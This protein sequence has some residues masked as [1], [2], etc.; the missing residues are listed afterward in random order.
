MNKKRGRRLLAWLLAVIITATSAPVTAFAAEEITSAETSVEESAVTDKEPVQNDSPNP[1]QETEENQQEQGAQPQEVPEDQPQAAVNGQPQLPEGTVDQGEIPQDKAAEPEVQQ[2]E[3][4]QPADFTEN[5]EELHISL[6]KVNYRNESGADIEIKAEDKRMDLT[7]LTKAELQKLTLGYFAQFAHEG[8][9]KQVQEGDSFHIVIPSEFFKAENTRLPVPV[10]N[11]DAAD[12]TRNSEVQVAQYEIKDNVVTV[13]FI[14]GVEAED[15]SYVKVN[16]QVKVAVKEAALR[17]DGNAEVKLEREDIVMALPQV[18]EERDKIDTDNSD[19]KAEEAGGTS[20]SPELPSEEAADEE[21]DISYNKQEELKEENKQEKETVKNTQDAKEN[22]DAQSKEEENLFQRFAKKAVSFFANLG[23]NE[24]AAGEKETLSKTF[25]N[26]AAGVSKATIQ[27][28]YQKDGYSKGDDL[29]VN[30]GLDLRLDDAFLFQGLEALDGTAGFPQFDDS[31]ETYKEY[32]ARLDKYLENLSEDNLPSITYIYDLGTDFT[33]SSDKDGK[34]QSLKVSTGE[35]DG[36]GNPVLE[37]IGTLTV[38]KQKEDKH[39]VAVV[40]F[41]KKA[42]NRD[43]VKAGMS[44]D[45]Q[46]SEDA[47]KDDEP[48][49]VGWRDDMLVVDIEGKL[50]PVDPNE[51]EKSDYSIEKTSLENVTTPYIDYTI[52]VNAQNDK[53]LAGMVLEDILPKAKNNS[54]VILNVNAV[55]LDNEDLLEDKEGNFQ[56]D[57][58]VVKDGKLLYQ[59]PADST[60]VKAEFTVRLAL[61]AD[62]YKTAISSQ[63]GVAF[64]FSNTA[65][66]KN[67]DQSKTEVTSESADTDMSLKLMQ[68]DGKQDGI[69]GLRYSW[70]LDINT[71]FSHMVDAYIADTICWS[72]HCYEDA[73]GVQIYVDGKYKETLKMSEVSVADAIS[74][75]ALSKENIGQV[76]GGRTEPFYYKYTDNAD[77]KEYAVLII[78]FKD[79]YQNHNVKIKYF[80]NINQHGM[81]VEE[82]MGQNNNESKN[83][84]NDA[85]FIWNRFVYGDG[86]GWDDFEWNVELNKDVSTKVEIGAKK[87]GS[88]DESTQMMSWNFVVNGYGADMVNT[89]IKDALNENLYDYNTIDLRYTKYSRNG[90]DAE[91]GIITANPADN[92]SALSYV[93]DNSS[94]GRSLNITVG[95]VTAHEYYEIELKVKVTDV[96]L[97]RQ[98]GNYE[99]KNQAVISAE[100]NGKELSNTLEASKNVPQTLIAKE[101]VGEYNYE[102]RELGWKTTIDMNHVKIF[103]GVV[104]DTLPEGNSFGTIQKVTRISRDAKGAKITEE[105]I[106]KEDQKTIAFALSDLKIAWNIVKGTKDVVTFTFT[107]STGNETVTDDSYIFEYKTIVSDE[108]YLRKVFETTTDVEIINTAKLTGW[109]NQKSDATAIDASANAEAVHRITSSIIEKNGTYFPGQGAIHWSVTFNKDKVD[110]S[111][112]SLIEEIGSQPLEINTSTL[113]LSEVKADGSKEKLQSSENDERWLENLEPKKIIYKIPNEY[114]KKTM[115]LEFDT[116]L[117]ESAAAGSVNNTARLV[118]DGSDYQKSESSDGGYDGSFDIDDYVTASPKPI[119]Q[120]MKTSSND[121]TTSDKLPLAGAEFTLTAYKK[122]TNGKYAADATY[123]K[124]GVSNDKGKC[125]F[126]NLKKGYV[127]A[128]EET[129]APGGYELR[130]EITYYLF[131]DGTGAASSKT[132][133]TLNVG[134]SDVKVYCLDKGSASNASYIENTTTI[135]N[136]PSSSMEFQFTKNGTADA[137]LQ[138]SVFLLKDKKGYLQEKRKTSGSDGK[139]QFGIIDPGKYTMTELTS[140][141]PYDQGAK[142]DVEMKTDGSYTIKKVSGNASVSGDYTAGYIIKNEYAKGTI[143]FSKADSTNK[144][145]N[146]SGAVFALLDESNNAIKENGKDITATSDSNGIVTFKN[147]PYRE[148]GYIIKEVTPPKGY[149]VSETV[150]VTVEADQI[151]ASLKAA[152][153]TEGKAKSYTLNLGTSESGKVTNIRTKGSITFTKI[154]EAVTTNVLGSREFKLYYNDSDK[155]NNWEQG[156]EVAAAMSGVDGRVTFSDIPYGNYILEETHPAGDN[157]QPYK[158]EF[159]L[160]DKMQNS[161]DANR[162]DSDG[163]N[164][165]LFSVDLGI[166]RNKLLKTSFKIHKTDASTAENLANVTFELKGKNAYNEE[167]NTKSSKTDDKGTAEFKDIPIGEYTLTEVR[168]KGYEVPSP[169]CHK[170]SVKSV[171]QSASGKADNQA[172]VTVKAVDE[173]NNEAEIAPQNNQYKITN[174]PI[175]GEISFKKVSS[176]DDTKYLKGAEFTLYRVVNGQKRTDA[177]GVLAPRTAYS[178]E[179]GK[180]SFKEAE[181]G[182]YILQET[183][184]PDGYQFDQKEIKITKADLLN[185]TTGEVNEFAYTV[186][187][188]EGGIL[189]NKPVELFIEKKDQFGQ[190]VVGAELELIGKLAGESNRETTLLWTTDEQARKDLSEKLIAGNTYTLQ[191][192]STPVSGMYQPIRPVTFTVQEDGTLANIQ[193]ADGEYSYIDG[194][195]TLTDSYYLKHVSLQKRDAFNHAGISDVEF[196]LYRQSGDTPDKE[197]DILIKSGIKT[198]EAGRWD[199]KSEESGIV[200]PVTKGDLS[201]GL[202]KGTYYFAEDSTT[203]NYVLETEP[204]SFTIDE[205]SFSKDAQDKVLEVTVE[206][207]PANASVRLK[208]V[209]G[210]DGNLFVDNTEF[211]LTYPDG[212]TQTFTTEATER[213]IEHINSDGNKEMITLQKGEMFISGLAKGTYSLEE[214]RA[215]VNYELGEEPFKCTFTVSDACGSG[216]VLNINQ[217]GTAAPFNLTLIQGQWN[218]QGVLNERRTGSVS[219]IKKGNPNKDES[220]SVVLPGAEFALFDSQGNPVKDAQGKDIT[221]ITDENGTFTIDGLSWGDYYLQETAAPEGYHLDDTRLEFTISYGQLTK[222]FDSNEPGNKDNVVNNPTELTIEKKADGAEGT[223]TGAVFTIEGKFADGMSGKKEYDMTSTGSRTLLKELI[224][225]ES[226]TLTE[227]TAP[228]GYELAAPI[229]FTVARSGDIV[230]EDEKQEDNTITVEDKPIEVKLIKTDSADKDTFLAGAQFSLRDETAGLDAETVI[231]KGEAVVLPGMIQGHTYTLTETKAPAGYIL[232]QFKPEVRFTVGTDGKV[233]FEDNAEAAITGTKTDTIVVSDN[234]IKTM[235]EKT[236]LTGEKLTGWEFEVTGIFTQGGGIPDDTETVIRVDDIHKDALNGHL[237]AGNRYTIKETKEPEGYILLEEIITIEVQPDGSLKQILEEGAESAAK[238]E[239]NG[240]I[241]VLISDEPTKFFLNKVSSEPNGKEKISGAV[242]EIKDKDGKSLNPM[243]TWTS[244]GTSLGEITHLPKGTYILEETTTPYGYKTAA[245][246]TFTLDEKNGVTLAPGSKGDLAKDGDGNDIITMT[247]TYIRGHVEFTKTLATLQGETLPLADARFSLYREKTGKEE[248][249]TLLAEELTTDSEGK[250]TTIENEIVR[251]DN[252]EKLAKGLG[253]GSYYLVETQAPANAVLNNTKHRFE[254]QAKNHGEDDKAIVKVKAENKE[255]TAEVTLKKIEDAAHDSEGISGAEF[256][257]AYK[258]SGEE[259]YTKLAGEIVTGQNGMATIPNLKKGDYILTE[260]ANQG[261]QQDKF[262]NCRFTISDKDAFKTYQV[263]SANEEISLTETDEEGNPLEKNAALTEKGIENTRI[264]GSVTLLKVDGKKTDKQLKGTEFKLMKEATGEGFINWLTSLFTGRKYQAAGTVSGEELAEDQGGRLTIENL[265]W[266]KYKLIETKAIDGY[267]NDAR[268]LSF[269]I[270]RQNQKA[271]VETDGGKVFNFQNRLTIRKENADKEPLAGA[272]F[273]ITKKGENIPV[274]TVT[275]GNGEDGRQ[276]GEITLTGELVGGATYVLHETKAP[277]G[278]ILPDESADITFTMEEDGRVT[279]GGQQQPDDTIT[280]TNQPIEVKLVKTDS[281]D[282]GVFLEGAEFSLQDE[283]AAQEAVTVTSQGEA[284]LLPGMIQGHTYTLTETKV[285][286]GYIVPNPGLET[287]FRVETDGTVTFTESSAV[288]GTGTDT[289][290]VANEPTR[291]FL[292]KVSNE[293]DGKTR[294]NGAVLEI[295]DADGK[296]LNPQVKWTSDGSNPGEIVNLPKG[297]YMLV[298]TTTPKGYFTAEPIGFE[299]REDNSIVLSQDSSGTAAKGSDGNYTITMT[300]IFI[301]GDVEFVKYKKVMESCADGTLEGVPEAEHSIPVGGAEF[302][303]YQDGQAAKP[304]TKADGSLV[305]A[306]SQAEGKV[307][308]EQIPMGTYYIKETKAPAGCTA[309]EEIYK[310]VINENGKCQGLERTDGSSVEGNVVVNDVLRTDIS[311]KKV[312]EQAPD[313]VLPGSTY[314]LYKRTSEIPKVNAARM[315]MNAPKADS[316]DELEGWTL[317]ATS[318]TDKDGMLTFK[319]VLMDTEYMIRELEA[320]DGS[321]VSEKPVRITF[322]ADSVTGEVK[323]A[324]IDNGDGTAEVN[325]DTGEI[326]WREPPIMLG[327]LKTDEAGVPLPGA[328]L[329][330]Q[331]MEGN[332]LESWISTD[333]Q[334]VIYGDQMG[335]RIKANEQYR[336]AEKKAPKGYAIADPVEFTVEEKLTGPGEEFIQQIVMINIRD[337]ANPEEPEEIEKPVKP[338]KPETPETSET[339]KKPEK[340]TETTKS[341]KSSG[342]NTGDNSPIVPFTLLAVLSLGTA[343]WVRRKRYGKR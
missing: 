131:G 267:K 38:T 142:F 269:E 94:S 157:Y 204:K 7:G 3:K 313:T 149:E 247:D 222:A 26:P 219:L 170:V 43:G 52:T 235:L 41:D 274:R 148:N 200:N 106:I 63:D 62:D 164:D 212:K 209:D 306:V 330:L 120:V 291:F 207:K 175:K 1:G 44:I 325:P 331:D 138:N 309:E 53:T 107:D 221:R 323:I 132:E 297:S 215:N 97:L 75:K 39:C 220:Q 79:T 34:P 70:T 162:A 31:K 119:L 214:T 11:C 194:V 287:K 340:S 298:E 249:D 224:A 263:N 112:M 268:E 272:E 294:I 156:H 35:T 176:E 25:K 124:K 203:E 296:P 260:T 95:N 311:M 341:A 333:G 77:G 246:I 281:Q 338:E 223:I 17:E 51:P 195:L 187:A 93:I 308:F 328:E 288:T 96:N 169:V 261:Y 216:A 213:Q 165:N 151:M 188:A 185:G 163:N 339:P 102:T 196:S 255:F 250:L 123:N 265:E 42:F 264:P 58:Y 121:D 259:N 314:G 110:I 324:S 19:G 329:E 179:D 145:L 244:D 22:S 109:I 299:L 321:Q 230:I 307:R 318:V 217:A 317:I 180:V 115:C 319:G 98:Q 303:L 238:I 14:E 21:P 87:A 248:K 161:L 172:V 171:N 68:K 253:E 136:T 167:I 59:F 290:T 177:D 111:G 69:N 67:A 286:S 126:V 337:K 108:E 99:I 113:I 20:E 88:Y 92:A 158:Q 100:V 184:S 56:A 283:T 46:V 9:E 118:K 305:T 289:I 78:P 242:L 278:Y 178:D 237:I 234:A 160:R 343:V 320:P 90:K 205:T 342:A 183:K 135:H 40:V 227:T 199:S 173:S 243:R 81:S 252:K 104:T 166:I 13:T 189:T 122:D 251:K 226:Y 55:K 72:D 310:A 141:D 50:K 335:G 236:D 29:G 16:L 262:L 276:P 293:P 271:S 206:N 153:S 82:W 18:V 114:G 197:H 239:N 45:L 54:S 210:E 257:L 66:L 292:D 84:S 218:N 86:P 5:R 327:F 334:Y 186:N 332:V 61:D 181:Y 10:Y 174:T 8:E 105:G 275:T 30:F 225:G 12:Y 60:A 57:K 32:S 103:A 182:D 147:I 301:R 83:I 322:A 128:L 229:I 241:K 125:T 144:A 137:A 101:A 80:T 24:R 134:G 254:I 231:S 140:D 133:Q 6:E 4:R 280:V 71:Q 150:I 27:V 168:E 47:L 127:Y 277:E 146:L 336:L 37:Q 143:K 15:V 258:A 155:Y 85:K 91:T 159:K 279:V 192:K 117:T 266:G 284:V 48:V 211:V 76:V 256:T 240:D 33:I 202:S 191:E 228:K 282:K 304:V 233:T 130:T 201:H 270:N 302:T 49:F 139:V 190:A 74:Y 300:D 116:E 36:S 154:N 312:S 295:R 89:V 315:L 285:P 152:S 65:S 316:E 232:P 326:I 273:T 64:Q 2:P 129:A 245:P 28:E 23:G 73:S 198:D 193:G 208:K